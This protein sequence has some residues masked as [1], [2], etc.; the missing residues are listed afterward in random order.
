M[1]GKGPCLSF[2]VDMG[3]PVPGSPI[4]GNAT[5]TRWWCEGFDAYLKEDLS[6]YIEADVE[7]SYMYGLGVNRACGGEY[8]FY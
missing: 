3:K 2:T 1:G 8:R 5:A 4:N 6:D 7:G